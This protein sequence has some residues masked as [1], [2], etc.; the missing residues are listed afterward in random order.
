MIKIKKV[1]LY[2]FKGLT[3]EVSFSK[4]GINIITGASKRGKSSLLDIVEYCLG[5]SDCGIAHGYIRNLVKWFSVII[6]DGESDYI[7]ARHN[8]ERGLKVSND[9]FITS[10]NNSSIPE[11][12]KIIR[13]ANITDAINLLTKLCNM[14]LGTTDVPTGQTRSAISIDFKNSLFLYFQNQDE[15]ANKKM[16]FHRQSEPF[17]PQMM[18]DTLPYFI[19]ATGSNR[20]LD[21]NTLRDLKRSYRLKSLKYE[22]LVNIGNNGRSK[23][24]E[25]LND[26]KSLNIYDGDL[27][28]TNSNDLKSALDKIARWNPFEKIGIDNIDKAINEADDNYKNLLDEKRELSFKI[29]S[30][31]AFNELSKKIDESMSEQSIRLNSINLFEKLKNS[32]AFDEE[33]K[34]IL[35]E[36]A[37]QLSA[38]LKDSYRKRPRLESSIE[39]LKNN[40]LTIS[41][42]TSD[43]RLRLKSL[44]K[45]SL[46][47]EEK[48]DDFLIAAKVSG[49]AELYLDSINSGQEISS[50][51][52]SLLFLE[53]QINEIE[54]NL[55]SSNIEEV[56]SSQLNII[57][58]DITRWARELR[59][60]HSEHPIKLDLKRLTISADTPEGAI[61]LYQMGSGENWVGYHLVTHVA[62]AKWFYKRDRPVARFIFLDQPSQV[63][64]PAEKSIN[65]NLDE[66]VNDEDR[67]A[68]KRMFKWLYDVS[69]NELDGQVQ[70]II[71]DH[72][73]IDEDWFQNSICD[74]K[75]RGSDYLIPPEWY[76]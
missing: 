54:S 27:E 8:P 38:E 75:W 69:M 74:V 15:I 3:R 53:E 7:I 73:D 16:I 18:K 6:S 40:Y 28:L 43:A 68:V 57:S 30:I 31:I 72:A 58:E 39:E 2:S 17:L 45:T 37:L 5:S 14:D 50:L 10:V 19:G 9:F 63:Y 62:L 46:E 56:L 61:P 55:G 32:S 26:A 48:K 44:I 76:A 51:K 23:A 52:A 1:C 24:N 60:E 25:L 4:P 47:I 29:N 42:K 11:P 71:T 65:G 22:E 59:L 21:K 34:T 49:K 64:F 67:I 20:I 35:K 12:E 13:N 66:I 41:K 33:I 36:N 70:I